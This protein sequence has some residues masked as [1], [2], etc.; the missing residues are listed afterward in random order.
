MYFFMRKTILFILIVIGL[1]ILVS[2]IAEAI[3]N[4]ITMDMIVR[5]VYLTLGLSII[6]I[7]KEAR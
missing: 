1:P 6:Y 4:I 5:C 2:F 7:L 3:A